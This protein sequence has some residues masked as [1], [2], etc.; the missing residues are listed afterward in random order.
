MF[1]QSLVDSAGR[2]QAGRTRWMVAASLG[3]QA[4]V[5]AGFVAVPLMWPAVLP[6]VV[7]AP[8]IASVVM[9]KPKVKADPPKPVD[10]HIT[11]AAAVH[12]PASETASVPTTARGGGVIA[13]VSLPSSNSGDV[14]SLATGNGMGSP[15]STG[16]GLA[17]T[18]SPMV[19]VSEAAP[20]RP[21]GPL[22]ISSGVLAGLLLEPIRPAYP[23]IAKAAGV[24][25]TVVL[26][27]IIDKTGRIT[28]LQVVSGPEM[29]RR[30]ALDAVQLARY[31]PFQLNG[32]PTEVTTTISVVFRM[33]S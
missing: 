20:S 17:V 29:L 28:G 33:Q 22:K 10:T 13:R 1:E 6:V 32:A 24:Q 31:Q 11:N 30:S 3:V 9:P 12:A 25:G 5:V 23:A 18:G 21:A 7:A 19:K 14:P 15:F 2:K 26:S 27:A 4:A 16:L 8:R